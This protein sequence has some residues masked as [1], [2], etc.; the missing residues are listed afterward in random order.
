MAAI[1]KGREGKQR[2]KQ[3]GG[4]FPQNEAAGLDEV[5]HKMAVVRN[6]GRFR[7]GGKTAC[8][9]VDSGGNV[10]PF[11]LFRHLEKG[12][13]SSHAVICKLEIQRAF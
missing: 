8:L 2:D 10:E 7:A 3:N 6:K 4:R 13:R 11:F 5:L 1:D 12:E 9:P